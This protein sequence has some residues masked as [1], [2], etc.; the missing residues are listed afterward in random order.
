MEKKLLALDIGMVCLNLRPQLALASI[1][2]NSYEELPPELLEAVAGLECGAIEPEVFFASAAAMLNLPDD[3]PVD[4]WFNLILGGEMTGM[5]DALTAIAPEWDFVFLSDISRPH[6]DIVRR[7]LSFFDRA[8][9]GVYSFEVGHRKPAA[10]MY[11][12]FERRFGRPDLY[13]DD[14]EQ[15]IAAALERNWNA[16]RFIDADQFATVFKTI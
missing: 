14:R 6:L 10:A 1:G 5:A 7:R 4:E 13:V 9:G 2:R 11:S 3:A 15:N 12:E 8:K 16:V